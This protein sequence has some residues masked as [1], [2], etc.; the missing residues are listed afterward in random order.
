MISMCIRKVFEKTPTDGIYSG[1]GVRRVIILY[2]R[3]HTEFY[4]Q[5]KYYVYIK[6]DTLEAR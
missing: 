5:N 2:L 1:G 6:H 4:A 3:S